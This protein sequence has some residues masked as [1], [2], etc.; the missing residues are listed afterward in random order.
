MAKYVANIYNMRCAC[1]TD[2]NIVHFNDARFV[3]LACALLFLDG[4]WQKDLYSIDAAQNG[5]VY[6]Y[7]ESDSNASLW[8]IYR[9]AFYLAF[10]EPSK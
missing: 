1:T 3:F 7:F 10:K 4:Q 5:N 9:A 8:K 2:D 6:K